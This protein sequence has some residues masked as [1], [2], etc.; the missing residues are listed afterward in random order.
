MDRLH[1]VLEGKPSDAL[2]LVDHDGRSV[3]YGELQLEAAAMVAN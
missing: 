3:S 2:A 1:Q